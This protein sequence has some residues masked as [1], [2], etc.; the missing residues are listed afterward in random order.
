MDM[1]A[2]IFTKQNE[3]AKE[4][5]GR[6][7]ILIRKTLPETHYGKHLCWQ[8]LQ[9]IALGNNSSADVRFCG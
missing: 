3:N 8:H 5:A 6:F 2:H 7:H 4:T 9:L 1:H